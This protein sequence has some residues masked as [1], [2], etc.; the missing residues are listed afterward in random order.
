MEIYCETFSV[1]KIKN[2]VLATAPRYKCGTKADGFRKILQEEFAFK[3][4]AR[5]FSE[6]LVIADMQ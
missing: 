6:L 1:N 5:K 2:A 4:G 3:D